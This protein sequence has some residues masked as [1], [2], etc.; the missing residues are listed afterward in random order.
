[1]SH[2]SV[3]CVSGWRTHLYPTYV[4]SDGRDLVDHGR[5]GVRERSEP[6]DKDLVNFP[7]TITNKYYSADV[8]FAAHSVRGL[9]PHLLKGVPAVVFVW[10]KGE[11]SRPVQSRRWLS[12][13]KPYRDDV[14]QLSQ[15]MQEYESEVSLAVR[16]HAETTS[17]GEE[18]ENGEIDD[19]LSSQ[20]FEYV[21]VT[22]EARPRDDGKET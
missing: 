21:C 7:W 8:H 4:V 22:D 10:T 13:D 15:D 2:S 17:T 3:I 12:A 6:A 5:A 20:G 18:E 9:S 14:E 16:M 19:F 11:V 1:M